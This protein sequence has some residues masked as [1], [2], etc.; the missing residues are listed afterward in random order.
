MKTFEFTKLIEP[1][2]P[3]I[4]QSHIY[5][6]RAKHDEAVYK[7]IV[8]EFY[9]LQLVEAV[10]EFLNKRELEFETAR[11]ERVMKKA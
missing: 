9:D 10:T 5:I 8:G 3:H 11:L 6:I 7:E 1:D 2:A 4:S